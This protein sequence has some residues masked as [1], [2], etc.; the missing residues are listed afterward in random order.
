MHFVLTCSLFFCA[1]AAT[2]A[3][4]NGYVG[5]AI[6]VALTAAIYILTYLTAR[7]AVRRH[8]LAAALLTLGIGA[9]YSAVYFWVFGYE[10]KLVSD[11]ALYDAV[12]NEIASMVH[13]LR[14]YRAEVDIHDPLASAE[15]AQH[16][17]GLVLLSQ[18]QPD[19]GG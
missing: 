7:S 1:G 16:E 4:S 18:P 14:D 6:F 15:E 19:R 9:F 11:A 10:Y 17:Y 13:T 3:L 5:L 2:L 8:S 12:A